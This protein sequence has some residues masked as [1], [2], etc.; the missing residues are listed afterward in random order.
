MPYITE[1][2][3]IWGQ[4]H[5][6]G[7]AQTPIEDFTVKGLREILRRGPQAI[8][9]AN[10]SAQSRKELE[11]RI[12]VGLASNHADHIRAVMHEVWHLNHK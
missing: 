8:Q 6:H 1:R 3:S 11:R 7:R 2:A 10:V 5:L 9:G 12:R 4:S